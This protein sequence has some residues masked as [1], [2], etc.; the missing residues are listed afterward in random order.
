MTIQSPTVAP[1]RSGATVL[2][3]SGLAMVCAAGILYA[4]DLSRAVAVWVSPL[5][6]AM[7]LSGLWALRTGRRPHRA[8]LVAIG[9]TATALVTLGAWVVLIGL[10]AEDQAV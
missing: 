3:A 5:G 8:V 9:L 4:T 1:E 10:N 6:A 7:V 2:L